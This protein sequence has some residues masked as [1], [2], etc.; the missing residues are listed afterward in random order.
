MAQQTS[1]ISKMEPTQTAIEWLAMIYHQRVGF[2]KQED[3]NTITKLLADYKL[4]ISR[5]IQK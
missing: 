3:I 5:Q 4:F 1:T 2:L